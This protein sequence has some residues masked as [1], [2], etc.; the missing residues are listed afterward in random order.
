MV[1]FPG[2]LTGPVYNVKDWI[3][4]LEDDNHDI[5][6]SEVCGTSIVIHPR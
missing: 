6:L 1:F 4:A 2:L 3:Q 5:D